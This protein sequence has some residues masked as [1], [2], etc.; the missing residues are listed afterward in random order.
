MT[1]P[2]LV[3]A[4]KNWLKLNAISWNTM[5]IWITTAVI[6][7]AMGA[8]VKELRAIRLLLEQLVNK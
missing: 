2:Y 1:D 6:M 4:H 3:T 8:A 5:L 7:I